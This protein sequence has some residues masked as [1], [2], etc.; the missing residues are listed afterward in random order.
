MSAFSHPKPVV[1]VVLGL[2]LGDEAKGKAVSVLCAQN[3]YHA[4]CR[5]SGGANAGHSVLAKAT[6][7]LVALHLLPSSVV[8]SPEVPLVIG[9]SVL[10]DLPALNEELLAVHA[11]TGAFPARILISERAILVQD[12]HKVEDRA[13]VARIGST[14]RGIGP[15][16]VDHVGRTGPHVFDLSPAELRA[17][18]PADCAV[19][20]FPTW[21]CAEE[22]IRAHWGDVPADQPLVM[23]AECAQAAGLDLV[24]AYGYPNCTT[25]VTTSHAVCYSLGL[26]PTC[27]REVFGVFKPY[28]TSVGRHV[29]AQRW[30]GDEAALLQKAGH[31]FGATTGRPRDCHPISVPDLRDAAYL[32]GVTQLTL[33]K[34]D[35]LEALPAAGVPALRVVT[36][37]QWAE[38]PRAGAINGHKATCSYSEVPIWT[39]GAV[40]GVAEWDQ[41]PA[42]CQAFVRAIEA[43]VGLPITI[44]GTGPA[45]EATIALIS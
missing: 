27:T 33:T 36:G 12:K 15:A 42:G 41:L 35:V 14:G 2:Q 37:V 5:V 9:A 13:N 19:E 4:C 29:V 43:L 30:A 34:I 7:Q 23:I 44:I 39:D 11:A 45:D 25:T 22:S 18:L 32:C 10:L 6:G 20:T 31:E 1:D 38:G 26:P 28:L 8:N 3:K 40:A 17:A 16:S 24:H 21:P